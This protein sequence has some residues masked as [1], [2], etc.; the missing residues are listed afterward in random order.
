MIIHYIDQ[1]FK[2][3]EQRRKK[4]SAEEKAIKKAE[5]VYGDEK[6]SGVEAVAGTGE[7]VDA[8]VA[9]SDS[10]IEDIMSSLSS[11]DD[12]SE[13]LEDAIEE[14]MYIY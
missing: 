12:E 9:L 8:D 13:S 5:K 1:A 10:E 3:L 7:Q 4:E 2:K 14:G 11:L 6:E